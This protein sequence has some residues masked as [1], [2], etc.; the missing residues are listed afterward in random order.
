MVISLDEFV[1]NTSPSK[2]IGVPEVIHVF[3][4]NPL[5]FSL[6]QISFNRCFHLYVVDEFARRQDRS[7]YVSAPVAC[8]SINASALV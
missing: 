7:I 6:Q 4:V 3:C 8:P 1:E 2:L 5:I